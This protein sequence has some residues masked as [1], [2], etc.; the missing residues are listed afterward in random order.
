[1][2]P[3]ARSL[4]RSFLN[5]KRP[6]AERTHIAGLNYRAVLHAPADRIVDIRTLLITPTGR[7]FLEDCSQFGC[8][9]RIGHQSASQ[10]RTPLRLDVQ[11]GLLVADLHRHRKFSA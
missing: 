10:P 3:E 11:G 5:R 2:L 7:Q 6:E 8:G 9:S 4:T 1:M